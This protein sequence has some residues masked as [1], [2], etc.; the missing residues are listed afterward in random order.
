MNKQKIVCIIPA[1]LQSSRFPKKIIADLHGKPLIQWTWEAAHA[2]NTFDEIY[3]AIDSFETAAVVEQFGGRYIMTPTTCNSGTERIINVMKSGM[4]DADIWVNWQCDEPFITRSMIDALLQSSTH[5]DTQLW[6]LKKQ[7]T[8]PAEITAPNVAKV[9]ADAYG[10]ALYF[11]RSQIPLIRDTHVEYEPI[12]YYKHIGIYAYTTQAL[13]QI[14]SLPTCEIEQ[15]EQL[16]QLRFLF[17]GMKIRLHET[18]LEPIAI[19]TPAD[20]KK[21]IAHAQTLIG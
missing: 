17:Y 16:E 9:V 8:N 20:L 19:D 11:S 21:A 15:A 10:N 12:T 7:I 3:L 4:I 13:K 1:R 18:D 5:H 2:T 14:A 6:T